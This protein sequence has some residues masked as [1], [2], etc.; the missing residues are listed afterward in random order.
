MAINR[1]YLPE[2]RRAAAALHDEEPDA[3]RLR[4]VTLLLRKWGW[5]EDSILLL[6]VMVTMGGAFL[7]AYALASVLNAAGLARYIL[8]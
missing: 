7:V 5:S 3:D 4:Q 1:S 8:S 6:K 2:E